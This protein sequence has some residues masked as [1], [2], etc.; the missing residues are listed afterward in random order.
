MR[1]GIWIGILLIRAIYYH[2]IMYFA[3][4]ILY[5]ELYYSE[6]ESIEREKIVLCFEEGM[7]VE[8]RYKEENRDSSYSRETRRREGRTTFFLWRGIW[9]NG[10][11][12]KGSFLL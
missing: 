7:E 10:R 8:R 3:E 11:S 4:E 9:N 6:D 5:D 1:K 12:E 2:Q